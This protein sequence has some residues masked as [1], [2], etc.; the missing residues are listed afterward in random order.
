MTNI[1]CLITKLF[2]SLFLMPIR[3]IIDYFI[4]KVNDISSCLN[5]KNQSISSLYILCSQIIMQTFTQIKKRESMKVLK[6]KITM[7]GSKRN[8]FAFTKDISEHI[9]KSQ[10]VEVTIFEPRQGKQKFILIV[11]VTQEG[12]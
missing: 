5:E 12:A 7:S 4:Y 6:K 8:S 11:D 10:D 2:V 9:K 1:F 3:N